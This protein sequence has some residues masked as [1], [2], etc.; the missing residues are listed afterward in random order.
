MPDGVFW[1]IPISPETLQVNLLNGTGSLHV[2]DL[3]VPDYGKIPNG[4][5][6]G[7]AASALVSFAIEWGGVIGRSRVNDTANGYA[8][9]LV[10]TGATIAWSAQQDGFTFLSDPASTSK[11]TDVAFLGHERN[12]VYARGASTEWP[13]LAVNGQAR[14]DGQTVT[15]TYTLTNLSATDVSGLDVRARVPAGSNVVDSWFSQPGRYPGTNNGFDVGWA[16]PVS[17]IAAGSSVGPFSIT[18]SIPPG[19]RASQV[20]SIGWVGFQL[21]TAGDAVSGWIGGG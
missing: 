20:Q 15:F 5:M 18:A 12:G 13:P 3:A 21:P 9:E 1:T 4:L 16:A 2:V 14:S 6:H 19:K 17:T 8:A 10:T 11:V 7:P